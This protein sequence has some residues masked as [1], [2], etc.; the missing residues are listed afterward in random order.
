LLAEA[1]VGSFGVV[2]D[3]P[4]GEFAVEE[5]EVGE[6][7]FLVVVHEGLLDRAIE[8]LGVGVHL[9]CFGVGV[10]ALDAALFEQFGE[11][12]F[13]LAAVVGEQ[14]RG[15]SGAAG[16]GPVRGRG[17]CIGR[18]WRVAPWQRPSARLDR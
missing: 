2:E 12:G 1:V 13:E 11:V 3:E 10:P 5:C 14:G 8:A 18:A 9:G 6:E 17:R 16:T 4:I 7:Q 15:G